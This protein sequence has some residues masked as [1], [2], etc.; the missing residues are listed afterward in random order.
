MSYTRYIHAIYNIFG[1][2]QV[3]PYLGHIPGLYLEKTLWFCSV[4]V[5][6]PDSHVIYQAYAW[7]IGLKMPIFIGLN[8]PL[9]NVRVADL[10]GVKDGA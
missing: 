8:M 4:P 10:W 7:Y 1:V 6:Y 3:Y 9:P 2:Y 5:T